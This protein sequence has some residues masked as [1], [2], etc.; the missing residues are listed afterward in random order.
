MVTIKVKLFAYVGNEEKKKKQHSIL[1]EN[2]K[3]SRFIPL[4]LMRSRW[5]TFVS[6]LL[7]T[8][9]SA[10]SSFFL[11][12]FSVSDQK[13]IISHINPFIKYVVPRGKKW[14]WKWSWSELSRVGGI[15]YALYIHFKSPVQMFCCSFSQIFHFSRHLDDTAL[16]VTD[17]NTWIWGWF[18]YIL[19]DIIFLWWN[20]DN[21]SF[22]FYFLLAAMA[23]FCIFISMFYNRYWWRRREEVRQ[24]HTIYWVFD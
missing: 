23:S 18:I 10:A 19:N 15:I 13:H 22:I 17:G 9:T 16:V 24:L 20:I 12:F 11:E 8:S 7:I 14:T 6:S 21:T 2:L 3:K 5:E 4:V 1:S